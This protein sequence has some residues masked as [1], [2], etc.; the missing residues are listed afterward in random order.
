MRY[1]LLLIM[2]CFLGLVVAC[3]S[4][5][6]VE[7]AAICGENY[8]FTEAERVTL[9]QK[10]LAGDGSA[11]YKLAQ[12]EF[13]YGSIDECILWYK[14]CY[15]LGYR[16]EQARIAYQSLEMLEKERKERAGNK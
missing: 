15:R 16:K 9:K 13:S 4:A 3:R 14:E 8:L 5:R 6:D 1:H 7:H 10:A 11:A 2:V 12:Y